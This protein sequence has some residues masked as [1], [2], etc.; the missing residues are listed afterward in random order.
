MQML[1]F[2]V[3]KKGS[4]E[5]EKAFSRF[6]WQGKR[7]GTRQLPTDREGLGQPDILL[8]NWACHVHFHMATW[9]PSPT[10]NHGLLHRLHGGV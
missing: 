3:P 2:W 6:I 9:N 10:L 7:V 4:Y 8:Y 5:I 1:P